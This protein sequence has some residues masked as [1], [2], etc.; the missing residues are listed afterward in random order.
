MANRWDTRELTL[1]EIQNAKDYAEKHKSLIDSLLQ[2]AE[3]QSE[4][5]LRAAQS[6]SG[7]DAAHPNLWKYFSWKWFFEQKF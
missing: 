3:K 1:T 5:G 6:P 4:M 2:F 7:E